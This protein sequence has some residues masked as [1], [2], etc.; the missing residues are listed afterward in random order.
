MPTYVADY[1]DDLA[2]LGQAKFSQNYPYPVL[3]VL[4][5]TGTLQGSTGG[6]TVVAEATDTM[7][8]STLVGRVFPVSKAKHANPGPVRIGRTSDNDICIPEYSISKFHCQLAQAG[9]EMKLVDTGSTNGTTVNGKRV[10]P[11]TPCALVG[12]ET[13]VMGR[14][15]FLFHRAPGFVAYLSK[16]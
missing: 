11:K 2:T 4:G 1:K 6:G 7:L 9:V 3:I 5:L 10:A 12:G 13:L 15:A 8:L 14:F 16:R